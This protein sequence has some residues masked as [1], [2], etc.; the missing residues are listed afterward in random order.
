[1]TT[2]LV[3]LIDQDIIRAITHAGELAASWNKHKKTLEPIL[4]ALE[5]MPLITSWDGDFNL[6]FAGSRVDI[7]RVWRALR[8]SGW[9]LS[10]NTTPPQ[11]NE[12]TWAGFFHHPDFEFPRIWLR[13]SSTTCR[14][15]ARGTK[16][17]EETI[18]ETLCF[19][20][21]SNDFI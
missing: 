9:K 5:D 19:E 18:W 7:I 3:D 8:A 4:N 12:S 11:A 2:K 17:V 20:V 6:S 15:V 21:D 1:M 10:S 14:R 16:M 13:F